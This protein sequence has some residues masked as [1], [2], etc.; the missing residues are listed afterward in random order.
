MYIGPGSTPIQFSAP[1]QKFHTT[2]SRIRG[3]GLGLLPSIPLYNSQA[4]PTLSWK[5]S[6]IHPDHDTLKHESKALQLL[7]NGP[8][9]AIPNNILHT[10]KQ[11]GLPA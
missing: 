8:F 9:N 1:L 6:F 10:L 2:V 5:A 7:T 4:F 3:L 11:L